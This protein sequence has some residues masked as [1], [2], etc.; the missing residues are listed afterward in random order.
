MINGEILSLKSIWFKSFHISIANFLFGY[1]VGFLNP[2][3]DNIAYS[4]GWDDS[5]KDLYSN[6][7]STFIPAGALIGS[8]ITG[9]ISNRFGR[10]TT[11]LFVDIVI[12]VGSGLSAVPNTIVF[13]LGRFVVGF[14]SGI[15]LTI[16]PLYVAET[17]PQSLMI[18]VGNL[19]SFLLNSGVAVSYAFGLILP[20][21]D[22]SGG[23]NNIWYF[24]AVFPG[25][26]AAYQF[27]YFFFTVKYDSPQYYLNK[28]DFSKYE[29]TLLEIFDPLSVEQG[30]ETYK[31]NKESLGLDAFLSNTTY[32][33]VICSS[34]YRKILR[35]GIIIGSLQQLSGFNS[36]IYYSSTI[37]QNMGGSVFISRVLTFLLGILILA[38]NLMT[39]IIM[40][41][42]GRKTILVYGQFFL[43]IVLTI[44]GIIYIYNISGIVLSSFFIYLYFFVFT[45]SFSSTMDLFQ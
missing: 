12:F 42:F 18:K 36:I 1:S 28:N 2:C 22:Y 30:I 20:Y 17:T 43:A 29:A 5:S 26:I 14:G 44:L 19:I 3:L 35:I 40:K 37:F 16:C 32:S 6:L 15:C 9:V 7:F 24:M 25:L 45:F 4:M 38:S 41:Y 39:I 13:G 23:L 34:N 33:E 21:D 11:M 27:F 31:K 10:R 8:S